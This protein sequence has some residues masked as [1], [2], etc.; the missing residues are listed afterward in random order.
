MTR[1]ERTTFFNRLCTLR[2]AYGHL[3]KL[4]RPGTTTLLEAMAE[5]QYLMELIEIE[6]ESQAAIGTEPSANQAV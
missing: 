4:D 5:A 2:E 6:N 3:D 1:R